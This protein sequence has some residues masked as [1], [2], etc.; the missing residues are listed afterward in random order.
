MTY[1]RNF[2]IAVKVGGKV[3]RENGDEVQLPFGSEYSVLLKNTNSV[4]AMAQISI[5][6]VSAGPWYIL[7]PNSSVEI[8]RFNNSGNQERGNKFKFIERTQA[9]ETHRG[10]K[11]EDG[12]V[13]VEVKKEKVWEPPKTVE[14]HT[15]H[16]HQYDYHPGRYIPAP[17]WPSY[18]SPYIIWCNTSIHNQSQ[19]NTSYKSIAATTRASGSVQPMAMNMMSVN[20]QSSSIP[21]EAGI[22]VPGSESRQ[23]FTSVWGFDTEPQTEVLTLKLIGRSGPVAVEKPVT[24]DLR[25][26]CQTCGK[27]AKGDAKFCSRCGT[28]LILI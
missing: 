4:R 5:D 21:N 10:I 3:L 12:L 2:V 1:K 14:H 20:M 27:R 22:T 15:Y 16:H 19:Q 6:G 8:E 26:V 18:P 13:R 17:S 28:S 25:A 24:V 7:G 9:V 11:I 23:A